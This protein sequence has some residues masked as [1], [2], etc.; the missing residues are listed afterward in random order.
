MRSMPTNT[1]ITEDEVDKA[2]LMKAAQLHP[3][4]YKDLVSSSDMPLTV[5]KALYPEVIALG[6][7]APIIM[8]M[9]N[10]FELTV[11]RMNVQPSNENK[12]H[13]EFRKYVRDCVLTLK[14]EYPIIE[15]YLTA[16][17]PGLLLNRLDAVCDKL[18]VTGQFP[19]SYTINAFV[20]P[21]AAVTIITENCTTAPRTEKVI[22]AASKVMEK[23]LQIERL[24]LD[25]GVITEDQLIYGKVDE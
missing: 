2:W 16:E 7:C 12:V 24:L 1:K 22:A 21:A 10:I 3:E 11:K 14:S 5:L 9:V 19:Y 15:D 23:W 20:Y 17:E 6:P 13:R 4:H 8:K 25:E 18:P